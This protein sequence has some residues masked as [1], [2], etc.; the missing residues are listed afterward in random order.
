L[1]WKDA[2][3]TLEMKQAIQAGRLRDALH[4]T[5]TLAGIEPTDAI[6]GLHNSACPNA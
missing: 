4:C 5:C 2:A 6:K 3:V 1:P